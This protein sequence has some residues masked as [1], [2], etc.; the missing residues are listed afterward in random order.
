MSK[1][2][3]HKLGP[4]DHCELEISDF[5]LF[6][7]PQASGKSTV[8]K[9]IFFFKN[10]KN[11]LFEQVKKRCLLGS[12]FTDEAIDLSFKKRVE[13]EIR[14]NFLQIFGR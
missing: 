4:I 9:S 3:I 8:A 6:T 14:S 13:R 7:G 10:I 1:I 2:I 12:L 11:I 5:T